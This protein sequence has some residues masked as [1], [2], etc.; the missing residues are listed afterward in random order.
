LIP[1][2]LPHPTPGLLSEPNIQAKVFLLNNS[3]DREVSPHQPTPYRASTFLIKL[4][5][6]LHYCLPLSHSQSRDNIDFTPDVHV[7]LFVTHI[8]VMNEIDWHSDEQDMEALM[9]LGVKRVA[10]KSVSDKNGN[11]TYDL[12]DLESALK[13][14][15]EEELHIV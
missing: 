3:L 6:Q 9:R 2:V 11:Y 4:A 1:T 12:H 14:I 10:I 13:T 15:Y 5:E 7:R 8:F